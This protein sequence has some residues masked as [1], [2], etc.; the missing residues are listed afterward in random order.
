[1]WSIISPENLDYLAA[2]EIEKVPSNVFLASLPKNS[3]C[4]NYTVL[5]SILAHVGFWTKRMY[6]GQTMDSI[7]STK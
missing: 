1:M 4:G 2:N 5:N 6:Y 3:A 7:I